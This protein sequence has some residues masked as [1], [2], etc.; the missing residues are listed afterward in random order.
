M[1]REIE[2]QERYVS[3][4]LDHAEFKS[5]PITGDSVDFVYVK[6]GLDVQPWTTMGQEARREVINRWC[7]VNM[8]KN[9]FITGEKG[10]PRLYIFSNCT[11]LIWEIQKKS[12]KRE[13]SDKHGVSERKVDNRDDH[14]LD[15]VESACVE[16]EN[17]MGLT[18]EDFR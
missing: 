6:C 13:K 3:T 1:W 11:N 16:L 7:D 15:C 8:T 10:A 4:Y 2:R 14:L 5:D 18:E 17:W 9:H 12:V